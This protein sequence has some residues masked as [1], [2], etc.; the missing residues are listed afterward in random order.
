MSDILIK[1]PGKLYH[2]LRRMIIV[3]KKKDSERMKIICK[4]TQKHQSKLNKLVNDAGITDFGVDN[5]SVSCLGACGIGILAYNP[6][7]A[8]ADALDQ[9]H[10]F[11]KACKKKEY[12]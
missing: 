10:K 9:F 5:F 3:A 11:E 8:Y 4:Y 7:V 12:I 1:S 6:K 2:L